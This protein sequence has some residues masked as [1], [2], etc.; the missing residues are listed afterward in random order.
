MKQIVQDINTLGHYLGKRDVNFLDKT[1]LK[2]KY[3]IEQAD[4]FVLFGGSIFCGVDILAD[5]IKNKIAKRY[6]I[7]GGSGHTTDT[8]RNIVEKIYPNINSKSLTE[9][10]IFANCLK[11]KYGLAVDFLEMQSTNC[12]NNITYL[13]ELLK[14]NR[15]NFNSIILCQDATMQYRMEATLRKYESNKLIVNYAS[16]QV[17]V[18]NHNNQIEFKESINGMW[19]IEHYIQLLMGEI[20]R[21][22]DNENGYGPKGKG[23]LVHVDIPKEVVS[24]FNRLKEHYDI[25]IADSRYSSK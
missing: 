17:D 2:Q 20:P 14:H 21:L 8:L 4:V 15:I 13:L 22:R 5:A 23:Y 3:G 1:I 12:G 18:Y 25:R 9:A 10:E 19:S 11:E 16:Y 6:I 7:V 24:A